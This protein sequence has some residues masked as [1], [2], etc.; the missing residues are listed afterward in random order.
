MK[1][2]YKWLGSMAAL[3]L[4]MLFDGFV[5]LCAYYLGFEPFVNSFGIDLPTIDYGIFVL[6]A[7]MLHIFQGK[8]DGDTYEINDYR[9]WGEIIS[10]YLSK[11]FI[12]LMLYIMYLIVIG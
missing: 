10:N 11:V 8:D 9:V 4:F 7:G 5:Y 12:I 2:L 1:G 3:I 6:F